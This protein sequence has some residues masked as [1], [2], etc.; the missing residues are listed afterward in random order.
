LPPENASII[1][2]DVFSNV[3]DDFVDVT[4]T[5]F[6]DENCNDN[7]ISRNLINSLGLTGFEKFDDDGPSGQLENG[8]LFCFDGKISLS[9]RWKSPHPKCGL[10]DFAE[11]LVVPDDIGVGKPMIWLKA[12][13]WESP[14]VDL[15]TVSPI[16]AP[17]PQTVMPQ[18]E[19]FLSAKMEK[20]ASA[21]GA[22]IH[23]VD[24]SRSDSEKEGVIDEGDLYGDDTKEFVLRISYAS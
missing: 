1:S 13:L 20:V 9:W 7:W 22:S 4:A 10:V 16:V 15:K 14:D 19:S 3:V 11:Y 18:F 8:P 6:R 23:S 21:A 5:F 12:S 2:I 17:A 24:G